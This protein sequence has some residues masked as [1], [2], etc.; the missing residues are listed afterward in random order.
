MHNV[1]HATS[2]LPLCILH[3]TLMLLPMPCSVNRG[4]SCFA[5][6][7]VPGNGC[8]LP[9]V[10][11]GVRHTTLHGFPSKALFLCH[12]FGAGLGPDPR[13]PA[14]LVFAHSR[15]G[16]G[17]WAS[18]LA[19]SFRRE[20]PLWE[21]T[22]CVFVRLRGPDMASV[23]IVCIVGQGYMG[24][25]SFLVSRLESASRPPCLGSTRTT[26][27]LGRVPWLALAHPCGRPG[28]VLW[29]GRGTWGA[30]HMY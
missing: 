15:S 13:G 1:H 29:D 24:G 12:Q 20:R 22:L 30:G 2:Q 3:V 23:Y 7:P 5:A 28:C 10:C 16:K 11:P 9:I 14:P 19:V 17:P 27:P 8:R 18:T 4:R 21:G 6:A 26:A 25:S